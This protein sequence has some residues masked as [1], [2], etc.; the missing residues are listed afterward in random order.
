M[1]SDHRPEI[2]HLTN[3]A[4]GPV[5]RALFSL[6]QR[7][8]AR[9]LR[10]RTLNRICAL[11]LHDGESGPEHFID[12]LLELL[13]AVPEVSDRDLDNVPQTGPLMV[14]ANHPFGVIEGLAALKTLRRVRP[15]VKALAN[16]LLGMVPEV[17]KHIIG[18]D[19]F[20]RPGSPARSLSGMK[21]ALRWFKDGHVLLVFPAGAVACLRLTRMMVAD[22]SWNPNVAGL[23]RR[24]RVPVLPLFVHGRNSGLFQAAGLLHPKLRTAMLPR[25]TLK[26]GAKP[27]SMRFG[28]CI[29]F[30]RLAAFPDNAELI[31]YLRFRTHLLRAR[32]QGGKPERPSA[33][34]TMEPLIAAVPQAT[35]R[36]EVSAIPKQ[37]VLVRSAPYSVFVAEAERIPA[38]LREIGR[39]RELSFRKVAEGS[40]R[41]LDLD[42][43]DATYSHLV[44]WDEATGQVV[45]GY[46][47]A[48]TDEIPAQKGVNALYSHSLF[49]YR[50]G[51]LDQL[52]PSL[53][54]GR[55]F[56]APTHQ[57]NYMPLL[58]LWKGL[59]AFVARHP[60]YRNLFGCVSISAE[61]QALSREIM[62]YKLSGQRGL[63]D[64][65]ALVRPKRPPRLRQI[66]R[67]DAFLSDPALGR[68]DDLEDLVGEIENGR[69]IPVLLRQYLK[70]GGRILA[71]N[72]D[73]SFGN[74]LDGLILVDLLQTDIRTLGRFMGEQ[75][76]RAFLAHHQEKTFLP[77]R[78]A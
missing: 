32:A 30:Q 26:K 77:S 16:S 40:G 43:F 14:V 23:V 21:Q 29:P 73:P 74:C 71:F 60:R 50:A 13:D 19:P 25:E 33:P 7:P 64:L 69:P 38:V 70:L 11:A 39:L 31:E 45:G 17:R 58:L 47:F 72:E 28:R 76:A 67:L 75:R 48:R 35:L 8:M 42:R 54:L 12:R 27:V 46:R 66:Q 41:A 61:Y 6:A 37:D 4:Q 9:M 44:L 62:V 1:P 34:R 63:P 10:L 18:V 2:F 65:A 68:M 57:K 56:V 49:H 53:E 59:A 3:P 36:R 55:S 20:N 15:D 24:A 22:P 5:G 52:G 51:L 78:A